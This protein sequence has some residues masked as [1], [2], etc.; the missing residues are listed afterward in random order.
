M[1]DVVAELV[2]VKQSQG[3]FVRSNGDLK[4]RLNRFAESFAVDISS[5]TDA[6]LERIDS[7]GRDVDLVGG[8]I[9]IGKTKSKSAAVAMLGASQW[10]AESVAPRFPLDNSGIRSE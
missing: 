9:T 10:I 8:L 5:I 2:A 3:K 7:N 1:A 4:F 6:E